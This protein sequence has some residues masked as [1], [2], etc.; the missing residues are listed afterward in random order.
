[1][2]YLYSADKMFAITASD[3][4]SW[5]SK[6]TLHRQ[7]GLSEVGKSWA[8]YFGIIPLF[9]SGFNSTSTT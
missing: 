9:A 1:M 4:T 2:F 3:V 8:K 5:A 6:K 7:F